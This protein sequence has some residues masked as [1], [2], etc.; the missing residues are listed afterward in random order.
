MS[1]ILKLA[2]HQ[3][4]L[5]RNGLE[6]LNL[7]DAAPAPFDLVIT[8]HHMP[9]ISGLE[10]VQCLREKGFTGEVCVMTGYLHEND[11]RKYESLG[12]AGVITKPLDLTSLRQSVQRIQERHAR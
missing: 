1:I 4:V 8:D 11:E 10:L 9:G 6:A 7:F 3:A 5:A 12:F 2:G